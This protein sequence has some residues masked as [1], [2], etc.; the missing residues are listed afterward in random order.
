MPADRYDVVVVGGGI[1][2]AGVAQAA[3]AAGYSVLVLEQQAIGAGT[4][5]RST[6]L[7]HGGLRYLESGQFSLVR[8]CLRERALLL[9]NAPELVRLR[10][11]YLPIY[12]DTRRR[13]WQL[14]AGLGLYALLGGLG[15]DARFARVARRAWGGLDGLDTAGLQTV[16]RYWDAQTDDAALTRAVMHSAVGLGAHLALPAR[17]VRAE[18]GEHGGLVHY[19]QGGVACS[20]AAAV[21]VNAAGPWAN[22]VLSTVTPPPPRLS[23]ELIAGTH[24][25]V[26]G[27]LDQGIYYLEAPRDGRAVFAAPWRDGILVGTTETIYRGDPAAVA[28]LAEECAYLMETLARYFPSYRSRGDDLIR[29]AFA[30]LRVLPAGNGTSFSRSRETVLHLDRAQ[31]PRLLTIYGGKLTSYRATAARVLRRLRPSLPARRARADTRTLKLK[32]PGDDGGT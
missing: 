8:E 10:P 6:K 26:A 20:C 1:H 22:T 7:I 4:S 23:V 31:R 12:R 16:F 28:P 13:P 11:F 3:A 30:G 21:L 19:E 24:I 14:R 2:G 17:L 15:A 32:P 5:S 29:Q 9:R 27:R 25:V 18:L